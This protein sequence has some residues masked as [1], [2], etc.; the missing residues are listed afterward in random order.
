[1]IANRIVVSAEKLKV[2]TVVSPEC[3]HAFTALRWG[4]PNLVGRAYPFN[5]V[6]ILELLDA[7]RVAVLYVFSIYIKRKI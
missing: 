2:K 3:G 6:H 4:G 5:V 7:G 1:M